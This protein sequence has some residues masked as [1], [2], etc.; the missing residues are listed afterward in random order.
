MADWIMQ[1]S[2][3]LAFNGTTKARDAKQFLPNP[4]TSNL[5]WI[6]YLQIMQEAYNAVEY[7]RVYSKFDWNKWSSLK[8]IVEKYKNGTPAK[9]RIEPQR[10]YK[11][12]ESRRGLNF[13][14]TKRGRKGERERI[15]RMNN[16]NDEH[17]TSSLYIYT[18]CY[19]ARKWRAVVQTTNPQ[20]LLFPTGV[21]AW[22]GDWLQTGKPK[23]AALS[24]RVGRMKHEVDSRSTTD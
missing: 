10:A 13:W 19:N 8:R 1:E 9:I 4:N 24:H 12:D 20:L 15:W 16:D 5:N 14:S 17:A 6:L 23:G 2:E 18:F 11:F 21:N 3:R 7:Q 22:S